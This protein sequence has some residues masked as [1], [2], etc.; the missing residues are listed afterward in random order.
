MELRVLI[1]RELLL[2]KS[3]GRVEEPHK[4]LDKKSSSLIHMHRV[5][6]E[7]FV[8]DPHIDSSILRTCRRV[9]QEGLPILYGDNVFMFSQAIGVKTFRAEQISKNQGEYE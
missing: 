3:G 9:Y 4:L 5:A 2:S 6:M 8:R 7:C 1:Y